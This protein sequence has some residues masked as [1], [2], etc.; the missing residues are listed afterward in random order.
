ML[1]LRQQTDLP[2]YVLQRFESNL[3]APVGADQA[4]LQIER[5]RKELKERKALIESELRAA[6][7]LAA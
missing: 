3:R 1:L 5:R 2:A 4:I 6:G 7:E